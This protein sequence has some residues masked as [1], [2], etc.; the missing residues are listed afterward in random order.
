MSDAPN[1]FPGEGDHTAITRGA[2]EAL[3][4][5][6]ARPGAALDYTIGGTL[7]TGVHSTAEAK[8]E[9]AIQSGYERFAEV[10]GALQNGYGGASRPGHAQAQF[11]ASADPLKSYAERQREAA[12]TAQERKPDRER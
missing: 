4:A 9:Y 3:E 7:E 1:N 8:R 11:N 5:Q 2:L 12:A 10:S 6:R